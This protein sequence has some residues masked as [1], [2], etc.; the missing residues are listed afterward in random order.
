M[1]WVIPEFGCAQ[2]SMNLTDLDVT[3]LHAAFDACQ[4]QARARGLR[5]TGSEIV[6]L[7]SR[8]VLLA[9]GRH[10]LTRSGNVAGLAEPAIIEHAIRTLGLADV[11]PFNPAER[12][13]EKLLAL[14]TT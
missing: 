2:V 7:V 3:P 12:L 1:G 9:A 4:T 5:V 11:K 6:G 8:A 13:I 14:G 10:Y